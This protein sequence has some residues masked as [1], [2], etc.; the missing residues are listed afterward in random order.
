MV[1]AVQ[2]GILV[3][4][5]VLFVPMGMAGW[6]LSRNKMLFFSGA[7]FITLAVGVHL[8]PYIP[9]VS[10]FLSSISSLSSPDSQESCLSFLNDIVWEEHERGPNSSRRS[11]NWDRSSPV[12]ACG[13]QRLGR[14]DACDLLNGSWIVVA[15]DSQARLFVLSLLKLVLDSAEMEGVQRDL[16]KRHSDYRMVDEEHGMKLDFIWAPYESNLTDLLLGFRAARRYPDVLVMG[17]G[18]WHMLHVNNA[19]DYGRL[20][21]TVKTSLLSL[22]PNMAEFSSD[23]PF[24]GSVSSLPQPS[25]M[26]WLGMPT[27]VNSKLNTEEKREKMSQSM[28]EAYLRELDESQLLRQRGGGPLLLLDIGSLSSNC[29]E[30]CTEDGMHYDEAVYE[31]GIHIML[32]ALLIVSHQH[33]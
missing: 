11:W 18:M 12:A 31:A 28:C 19:S 4:C 26:F 22:L 30:Q 21:R 17:T 7:L 14:A 24:A 27:L 10:V 32:N 23:W 33:V 15:G 1:G 29:G 16:F 6:H 2:F 25:H 3:A 8:T 13:F 9:S 5:V 20:L